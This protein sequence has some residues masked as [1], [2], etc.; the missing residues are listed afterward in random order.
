MRVCIGASVCVL[1]NFQL[2]C[3]FVI[4]N[5]FATTCNTTAIFMLLDSSTQL[6]Y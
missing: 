3:A 5:L 2:S 4:D 1:G 6:T